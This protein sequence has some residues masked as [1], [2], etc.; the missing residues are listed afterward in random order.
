MKGGTIFSTAL[1]SWIKDN[2]LCARIMVKY[3][4]KI[5]SEG[6]VVTNATNK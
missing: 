1:F 4:G 3:L 5:P 6:L 2:L